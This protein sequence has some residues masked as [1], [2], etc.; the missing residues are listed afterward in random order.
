MFNFAMICLRALENDEPAAKAAARGDIKEV[1]RLIE[2]AASTGNV[3]ADRR[4]VLGQLHGRLLIAAGRDA[5]A[6]EVF[7]RLLQVYSAL[8]RVL[9]RVFASLDRGVLELSQKR[10]GRAAVQFNSVAD[11]D[12]APPALRV[13]ALVGLVSALQILGEERRIQSSLAFAVRLAI[14]LKLNLRTDL[15]RS[16]QLDFN[17]RAALLQSDQ[18]R[19]QTVAGE[20]DHHHKNNDE[21]HSEICS[22]RNKLGMLPLVNTHLGM[23][24]ALLRPETSHSFAE[25]IRLAL[26]VFRKAGVEAFE[27]TARIDALLFCVA[28][29]KTDL[30][31][32][33]LC[34][35]VAY[36]PRLERHRHSIELTL[37]SS[38]LHAA[39]GQH[40]H[41]L[42]LYR[43]HS[44]EVLQRLR[45]ELPLLPYSRFLEKDSAISTADASEL[46]LPLRYRKAYRFIIEQL[47]ES[48]LSIRQVA[49]HI[50]VTERALQMTFRTNLGMSPAEV[51]R[52]RRL[53]KIRNELLQCD[54]HETVLDVASRWGIPS[55]S[56]F[57]QNYRQQFG[58]A[59]S[60]TLRGSAFNSKTS[61]STN[62]ERLL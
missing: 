62:Y 38:H 1:L 50:D 15:L 59:P 6:E 20:T 61:S 53:E 14:P 2:L 16:I 51:I 10:F 39:R 49:A 26:K 58:E 36:E 11:D 5:E 13:E 37:C 25:G 22:L 45:R 56:T 35:L 27:D 7:Q 46:R 17:A 40:D 28:F 43:W 18:S 41:A 48:D 33:L 29:S 19:Q 52:H 57:T 47:S 23:L 42:R 34:P 44:D 21:L 32:E 8:P 54:G 3:S 60:S 12:T 55:R 9:A 30:V 31:E 24:E 4:A